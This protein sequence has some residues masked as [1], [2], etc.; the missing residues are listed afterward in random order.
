LL[1]FLSFNEDNGI[2][3]KRYVSL[4][5]CYF[6]QSLQTS[7][8][9]L[10]HYLDGVAGCGN[11][12]E[13]QLRLTFFGLLEKLL[14]YFDSLQKVSIEIFPCYSWNFKARDFKFLIK[15]KMLKKLMWG[16]DS[17]GILGHLGIK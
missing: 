1:R 10:F 6:C 12:L 14:Q 3:F 15:L 8:D 5:N 16:N 9:R 13:N 4:L 11:F 17:Y 7:P 2:D